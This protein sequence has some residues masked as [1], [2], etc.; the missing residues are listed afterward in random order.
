MLFARRWL[1]LALAPLLACTVADEASQPGPP[2]P[3]P[4]VAAPAADPVPTSSFDP[5]SATKIRARIVHVPDSASWV[6]YGTR[7]RV[8]AL[9][10]EV[11]DVG[12]PL[13]RMLLVVA[14]PADR[15]GDL[16]VVGATHAFGLYAKPPSWPA[17]SGLAEDRPTRYVQ[18]I[19]DS[20]G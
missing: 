6:A 3:A 15:C 11:L 7:Q 1:I 14:C 16:F 19:A 2:K 20:P 13:P 12:D 10:I 17:I 8:G 4:P 18:S 9:E 5:A